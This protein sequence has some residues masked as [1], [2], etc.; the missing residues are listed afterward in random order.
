MGMK[1]IDFESLPD[2]KVEMERTAAPLPGALGA[3]IADHAWFGVELLCHITCGL[4][5]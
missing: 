4:G 2:Q 3:G 5:L 1:R